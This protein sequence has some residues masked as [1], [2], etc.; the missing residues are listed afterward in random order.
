M[1]IQTDFAALADRVAME[2]RTIERGDRV[3][4]VEVPAGWSDAQVEAWLDWGDDAGVGGWLDGRVEAWAERLGASGLSAGLFGDAAEARAFVE[5]LAATVRLGLGA[6]ATKGE[7]ARVMDLGDPAAVGLLERTR[8]ART[9]RRLGAQAAEALGR[10]A[11]VVRDL[12]DRQEASAPDDD[13]AVEA[14]DDAQEAR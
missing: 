6:P 11:E 1:R 4:E 7:P 9:A 8:A 10:A 12:I 14:D 5:N 3:R 13:A 2:T